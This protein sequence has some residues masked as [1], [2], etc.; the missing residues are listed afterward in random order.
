MWV[1]D[2]LWRADELASRV[3]IVRISAVVA[4]EFGGSF[5]VLRALTTAVAA[6]SSEHCVPTE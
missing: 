6:E 4:L 5:R 3:E 2:A 1:C